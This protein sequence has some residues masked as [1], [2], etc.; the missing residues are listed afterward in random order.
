MAYTTP[1]NTLDDL[2]PETLLALQYPGN[3]L[4][5]VGP[6]TLQTLHGVKKWRLHRVLFLKIKRSSRQL[7]LIKEHV[8]IVF[9]LILQV[10]LKGCHVH[11]I[12]DSLTTSLLGDTC[13]VIDVNSK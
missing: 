5:D 10:L 1:G 3:T 8:L 4:D 12:D 11:D 2:G 9:V 6:E 7:L 13:G